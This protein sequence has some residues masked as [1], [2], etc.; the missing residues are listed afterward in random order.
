MKKSLFQISASLVLILALSATLNAEVKLPAIFG[1]NMVLQQ[2]TDAAIWGTASANSTVRVTTSW[3]KKTYSARADRE[4]RWK[5]KVATPVAGGPYNVRISDG[6]T[7]TLNNVL[8]GEVWICSGQSNMEMPV[9]GYR[10]QPIL[11]STEFIAKSVNP[12]IRLITVQNW[13]AS[14]LWM[15]S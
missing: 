6:R 1:D 3:N 12:D 15:I 13:P 10:N 14:P 4:G 7:I 2:Q 8:I 5:V 9:K 11:G